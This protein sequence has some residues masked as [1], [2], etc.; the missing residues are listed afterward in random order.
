[1][2]RKKSFLVR[3]RRFINSF[4]KFREEFIR[5]RLP[6]ENITR[7]FEEMIRKKAEHNILRAEIREATKNDAENIIN[8]YDRAWHSTTMPYHIVSKKKLLKLLENPDYTFLIAKGGA[9]DS[10]I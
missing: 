10:I 9:D 3:I 5:L 8:L 4:V 2:S 7:E 1:M 6:V